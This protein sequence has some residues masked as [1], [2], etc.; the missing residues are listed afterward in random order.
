M[1]PGYGSP[2]GRRSTTPR[3]DLTLRIVKTGDNHLSVVKKGAKVPLPL[4]K[5][6]VDSTKDGDHSR[7]PPQSTITRRG[8]IDVRAKATKSSNCQ[9]NAADPYRR[10]SVAVERISGKRTGT[11]AAR[12]STEAENDR[13]NMSAPMRVPIREIVSAN[14]PASN[15]SEASSK[16]SNRATQPQVGR[17]RKG[18]T[19][20]KTGTPKK[21]GKFVE[22]LEEKCENEANILRSV[23]LVKKVVAEGETT[24]PSNLSVNQPTNTENVESEAGPSA[25][26]LMHRPFIEIKEEPLSDMETSETSAGRPTTHSTPLNATRRTTH[27]TETKENKVTE[28]ELAYSS[29]ED[30][31]DDDDDDDDSLMIIEDEEPVTQVVTRNRAVRTDGI[32]Q[33]SNTVR[34]IVD[35][36]RREESARN[37]LPSGSSNDGSSMLKSKISSNTSNKKPSLTNDVLSISIES[38][39]KQSNSRQPQALAGTSRSIA[40]SATSSQPNHLRISTASS[41]V[42]STSS[43]A[44]NGLV[45]PEMASAIAGIMKGAPPRLTPRPPNS[46]ATPRNI[47][48]DGPAGR[49]F[50]NMSHKLNDFFRSLLEDTISDLGEQC[51]PAKITTLKLALEREQ[52]DRTKEIAEL[53]ANYDRLLTETRNTYDKERE[54]AI[55][56]VRRQ[57]EMERFR[58]V[59][60]T[61]KTMWCANCWAE[62][63]YLCCWNTSYCTESCQN[64][65]WCVNFYY[66]FCVFYFF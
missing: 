32:R 46:G 48:D 10:Q 61:K 33:G 53:K 64:K 45:S 1:V 22:D 54:R 6:T 66:C 8:T 57:G 2:N 52:S 60:E 59:R 62:S 14:R 16:S 51:D 31:Y 17:K 23:G 35:K 12:K 41:P 13:K 37:P 50:A 42:A 26:I 4:A 25:Q 18:N 55:E 11:A 63:Q 34:D 21:Q 19:N 43:A 65:H 9:A 24:K 29:N 15:V 27:R 49:L 28:L 47:I 36:T 7:T 39:H 38:V 5:R 58:A 3:S 20:S 56:E 30:E 44:S 40:T